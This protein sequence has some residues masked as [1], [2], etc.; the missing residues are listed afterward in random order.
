MYCDKRT[1]E[2]EERIE[3]AG[4][5]SSNKDNVPSNSDNPENPSD[6]PCK[7]QMRKK[8]LTHSVW[9]DVKFIIHI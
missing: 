8:E 5:L 4:D 6:E 2:T 9:G 3:M 1:I 7:P